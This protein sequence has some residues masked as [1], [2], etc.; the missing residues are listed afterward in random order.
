ME[1]RFYVLQAFLPVSWSI[2]TLKIQ[3]SIPMMLLL[4]SRGFNEFSSC[5][6][7]SV[8]ILTVMHYFPV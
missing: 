2:Y 8:K 5:S 6:F 3:L 1:K 7:L 4:I